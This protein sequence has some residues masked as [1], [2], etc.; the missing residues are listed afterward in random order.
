[1]PS[2]KLLTTHMLKDADAFIVFFKKL[3]GV[4]AVIADG[5]LN[6]PLTMEVV[7]QDLDE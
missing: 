6:L 4:L 3:Q 7:P 5:G 2:I 1:M